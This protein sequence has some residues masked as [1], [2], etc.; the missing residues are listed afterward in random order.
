MSCRLGNSLLEDKLLKAEALSGSSITL[1]SA[2]HAADAQQVLSE[3]TI[4]SR[5]FS[6]LVFSTGSAVWLFS[7][8]AI[9]LASRKHITIGCSVLSF[10][11]K[12]LL[13][14]KNKSYS[15]KPHLLPLPGYELNSSALQGTRLSRLCSFVRACCSLC[16]ECPYPGFSGELLHILQDSA[17]SSPSLRK[18]F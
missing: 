15:S 7:P 1:H 2:W 10:N 18:L 4:H 16:L 6:G 12:E 13:E 17:P 8:L 9:F 5:H 14:L 3:R 11:C